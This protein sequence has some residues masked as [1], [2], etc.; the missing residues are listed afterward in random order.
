MFSGFSKSITV[1]KVCTEREH[2]VCMCDE[3]AEML[4]CYFGCHKIVFK[5][6]NLH[7]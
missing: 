6:V 7:T 4:K 5:Y 2:T 1:H 3:T